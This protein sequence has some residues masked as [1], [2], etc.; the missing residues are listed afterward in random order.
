[1]RKNKK[2]IFL[3]SRMGVTTAKNSVQPVFLNH[4]DFKKFHIPKAFLK[5]L[6][7]ILNSRFLS[8]SY[9]TV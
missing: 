1:M 6:Y 8:R 7:S 2:R 4:E 5:H 3:D 9:L